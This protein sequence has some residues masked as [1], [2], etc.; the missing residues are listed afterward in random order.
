MPDPDTQ[1][2]EQTEKKAL[3]K[4][5]KRKRIYLTVEKG[6]KKRCSK[7]KRFKCYGLVSIGGSF[8]FLAILFYH[9]FSNGY[10]AFT[11]TYIKVPVNL[12]VYPTETNDYSDAIQEGLRIL[13]PEVTERK[14]IR[15]LFTLVSNSAGYLLAKNTPPSSRQGT[16]AQEVWVIASSDVDMYIKGKVDAAT[17]EHLRRITDIQIAIID[18]LQK[19]GRIQKRFNTLFLVSGDSREPEM[20]GLLG[21]LLGS[22]FVV[23]SCM[24][25]ALPIGIFTAIYLEEFAPRNRFSAFIE[26]NINNLAAVPSIVY[27]LLGL[28]IFLQVFGIPRSA[29]LAGGF[30]L[31]LIALPII[32][33]TTRTSL[34]S[35]PLS[36]REAAFALGATKVQT[37]FH[38]VVPLAV[39]GI[40]TGTILSI[41]RV[42]GETAPLLMIGMVAFIVDIP[43]TI[44]EP[45]TALPVQ[46]YLWSDSPE[47]GFIEKT[48]AA[49]IVL[50]LFLIMAN[51]LATYIRKKYEMKW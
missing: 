49:I 16:L 48:S 34:R 38:H 22:F 42:L 9:I 44:L 24:S 3:K 50:L 4:P 10:S 46:I 11:Q 23:L 17:P 2:T 36:I 27:G 14:P 32:V 33:I 35:V 30:S 15:Q 31:A 29:A 6:V 28:A 37:T 51:V 45:A 39:P 12:S 21:S 18:K 40:M 25:V 47:M 1:P 8:F 26:V 19:D 13:F 41:A 43:H 5:F 20:A 7:E